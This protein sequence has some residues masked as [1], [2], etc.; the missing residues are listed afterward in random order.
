MSF[1]FAA[2]RDFALAGLSV[3]A[4]VLRDRNVTF[5]LS[6]GTLLGC[7]RDGDLI[8]HDSDVDIGV[9]HEGDKDS[10]LGAFID[11]GFKLQRKCEVDGVLHEWTLTMNGA[12]LDIFFHFHDDRGLYMCVPGPNGAH[13]QY[14]FPS[15]Q[16][17]RTAMLASQEYPIPIN[18]EQMLELQYGPSWRVPQAGWSF[19]SDPCNI[20]RHSAD[21]KLPV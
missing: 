5:W 21:A 14:R 13:G 12:L 15:L 17:T 10:L 8:P 4:K 16:G 9:L 18:A 20:E 19:W 1:S 3:A 7:V 2:N 11:V 6:C